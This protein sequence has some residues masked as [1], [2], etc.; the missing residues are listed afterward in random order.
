MNEQ[1]SR[2]EMLIG[3]EGVE[4]LQNSRVIIFGVGGVGGYAA[5]ALARAGVGHIELVDSDCVALSNINRQIIATHNTV[6]MYKTEAM[7]DRIATI[8][9]E[10]R[11]VCHSI[12]F[13]N[14]TKCQFNFTNYDYVIDAIDSLGAKIELIASAYESGTP[15]ISAM[16]AGNKLDPTLFEVSDISKTT[17][18][19]LARAVRIALRK[20]G[21]NHLKVVYSKEEPVVNPE[22]SDGERRRVPASI[23]FVPSV[24][25]LILAG[26]VVKDIAIR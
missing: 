18:C 15:I 13:D 7:R 22:V 21:I 9:P 17:V 11:V 12:F 26:E 10:C 4:K 19:P 3:T 14:D 25:G 2:T 8:N 5:E 16:G 24:M 1:H 20:R 6:G 23:S